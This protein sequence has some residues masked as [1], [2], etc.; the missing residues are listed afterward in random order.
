MMVL[1]I[2]ISQKVIATIT[3]TITTSTIFKSIIMPSFEHKPQAHIHACSTLQDIIWT[4]PRSSVPPLL[5][6]RIS[7][8]RWQKTFDA[9]EERY[10]YVLDSFGK[11]KPWIF[12]PCFICCTLPAMA[13]VSS[14]AHNGWMNLLQNEQQYYSTIGIQVSLAREIYSSGAGSD[15]NFKNEIVGL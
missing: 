7:L 3:L 5:V 1:V 6:G 8:Q 15:R 10:R 9:V 14:E 11:M 13:T 2:L 4:H 12:I